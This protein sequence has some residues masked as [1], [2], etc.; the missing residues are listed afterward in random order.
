M[1][2]LQGPFYPRVKIKISYDEDKSPTSV[3]RTQHKKHKNQRIKTQTHTSTQNEEDYLLNFI[4]VKVRRNR[5]K[6]RRIQRGKE[7][8]K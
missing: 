1:L 2:V 4:T 7:T 3:H 6:D 8:T 5:K